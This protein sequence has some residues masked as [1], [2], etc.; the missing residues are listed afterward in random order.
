MPVK[1]KR[2][3]AYEIFRLFFILY[4]V[5]HHLDMF[6]DVSIPSFSPNLKAICFEGG[7][8]GVSFF[9]I[10]SGLGCALGYRDKLIKGQ[11]L[12]IQFFYRRLINLWPVH[13]FFLF[14]AMVI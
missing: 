6:N 5:L 12:P 11:I 9:F 2:I 13:L 7:V 8:V 4:M 3:A 10:L 1:S 14:T